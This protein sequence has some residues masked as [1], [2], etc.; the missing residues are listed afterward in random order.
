VERSRLGL[1]QE[2]MAQAVGVRRE[3]WLKYE[4][5]AEPGASVLQRAAAQGL[6]VLKV[7]AAVH[8]ST[9]S[10]IGATPS[11]RGDLSPAIL[12]SHPVLLAGE[13]AGEHQDY[14]VVPRFE[15]R[16]SAGKG[17]P[18]VGDDEQPLGVF[19]FAQGW[20]QE[21]LGRSGRG[22]CSVRVHGDSMQPTLLQGDEIIIDRQV[23]RVDVSGIYVIALRGDLLVK[24]VQRKLDGSL[25]VKSDN[26]A[27][28][29]EHIT[30]D[31]AD[32]FRV[33]G[34]MVWPRVR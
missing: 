18:N 34:R 4:R 9:P 28:E 13:L 25:V 11:D 29:P 32:D 27:Y 24:R 12:S 20:M 15:V 16:V 3:Q 33:V 7:L 30:S 19:A 1:S 2:A 22:F 6:D 31:S 17:G 26:A 21:N 14:V 23:Q 8:L 5:G 10:K